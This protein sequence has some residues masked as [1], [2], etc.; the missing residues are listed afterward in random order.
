MDRPSHART[1]APSEAP[2]VIIGVG[3]RWRGDDGAGVAV[4]EA[5]STVAPAGPRVISH[6]FG[7]L[8]GLLG[9]WAA[10]DAVIIVDA[11][12]AGAPAGLVH[13][14]DA[15]AAPLPVALC[16]SSTHAV[17]VAETVE[18]ARALDRLPRALEVLAVEGER[19]A[20]GQELSPAV[21]RAVAGLVE[22][23]S[24]AGRP[25]AETRR[26]AGR[27]AGLSTSRADAPQ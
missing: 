21:R 3:N 22:E 15:I 14:F 26:A 19:F 9:R 7:D 12:S 4:A 16:R 2:T 18:L 23:L 10:D 5:L 17:G 24:P 8:T 25:T 27:P 20:T 6:G 13:R 1:R 11:A